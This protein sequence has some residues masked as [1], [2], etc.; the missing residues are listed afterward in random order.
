MMTLIGIRC[1]HWPTK[2]LTKINLILSCWSWTTI[3]LLSPLTIFILYQLW[4]SHIWSIYCLPIYI[5]ACL[6][7]VISART[8]S[9]WWIYWVLIYALMLNL[10]WCWSRSTCPGSWGCFDSCCLRF[11]RRTW[12]NIRNYRVHWSWIDFSRIQS[13]L[14][15]RSIL[16]ILLGSILI[17]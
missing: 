13:L 3:K 8:W 17:H 11:F 12:R 5:L 14:C 7:L 16:F 10:F 2:R 9:N 6:I 15:N 4:W 1:Y